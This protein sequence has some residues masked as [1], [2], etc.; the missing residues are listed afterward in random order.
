MNTLFNIVIMAEWTDIGRPAFERK[1]S[2]ILFFVGFIVFTTFGVL[3]VII[4]VIVDNTMEAAKSMEEE[5]KDQEKAKRLELLGQ[6]RDMVFALDTDGSVSIAIDE[7]KEG[8][9]QPVLQSLLQMVNLPKAFT[10]QE[11]MYLMDNNSDEE[12]TYSEFMKSFY[13]LISGDHFQQNCCMHASLNS[14]KVSVK[15]T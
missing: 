12:L 5:N 3:N 14:I 9:D 6:I 7:L 13:R 11:L 2:M 8:W 4:G 15:K 10:P 1:P